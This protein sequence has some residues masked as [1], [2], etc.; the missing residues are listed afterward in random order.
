MR[1][2]DKWGYPDSRSKTLKSRASIS[3]WVAGA[4][5]SGA[6]EAPGF[7]SCVAP[8]PATRKTKADEAPI[9]R[10]HPTNAG[11]PDRSA[12]RLSNGKCTS[13]SG[14]PAAAG[15]CRRQPGVGR[16]DVGYHRLT[17]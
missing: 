15:R 14:K 6:K 5:L 8:T 10:V 3:G 1:A 17:S 9:Y 13:C 12:K 2:S 11:I 16:T 4:G 7:H